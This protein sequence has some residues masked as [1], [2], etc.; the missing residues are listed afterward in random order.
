VH[1]L[2]AANVQSR[3]AAWSRA[4]AAFALGQ[5]AAGY[6]LSFVYARTGDYATLFALGAV[7]IAVALAIDVTVGRA[8][9]CSPTRQP[10]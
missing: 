8:R 1:E 2:V 9:P 10:R 5:A 3:T 4:T 7:A 6:G